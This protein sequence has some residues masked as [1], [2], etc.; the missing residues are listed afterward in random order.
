MSQIQYILILMITLCLSGCRGVFYNSPN[1]ALN[2]IDSLL[3]AGNYWAAFNAL[4]AIDSSMLQES[5]DARMR[6]ELQKIKAEDK[7]NKPLVTDSMIIAVI[8]YYEEEG[9]KGTLP[10]AYYYAGRTYVSLYDAQRALEYFNKALDVADEGDSYLLSKIHSQRGE[11]FRSQALYDMALKDLESFYQYADVISDSLGMFAALSDLGYCYMEME[12]YE[13]SLKYYDKAFDLASQMG[14][15]SLQ[16]YANLR[17]A[18]AYNY[19]DNY[20]LAEDFMKSSMENVGE[21][22]KD[23]ANSIAGY[24]F[25]RQ[26]KYELARPYYEQM[27][28]SHSI[29]SR[30]Q[31]EAMLLSMA[32]NDR[33]IDEIIKHLV[34][35][36]ELTDSLSLITDSGQIARI[37]NLYNSQKLEK[38]KDRLKHLNM[39]YTYFVIII[40]LFIMVIISVLI[41]Y[42]NRIRSDR[43]RLKYNNALL[44][45]YLKEEQLRRKEAEREKHSLLQERDRLINDNMMEQL[46]QSKSDN[47]KQTIFESSIYG[48]LLNTS[49]GISDKELIEVEELINNIFPDFTTRLH[50]LG[51]NKPQDL[52]VCLLLKMG[53]SP[54]HIASLLSRRES[55]ITNSRKRLYKKVVGKEGKTEEFDKIIDGI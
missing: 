24:I 3:D 50:T 41:I 13:T 5:H 35:Y 32:A 1:V 33:N 47:R 42:G 14:D 15:K 8:D 55:T 39:Q 51:V 45:Q 23:I 10:E 53:F 27:L 36:K 52:R 34:P 11:I 25:F 16:S 30:Q 49:K 19:M 38:E 12:E 54:S 37:N 4:V 7:I 17:K 44:D 26:H 22:Y 2:Y 43:D 9:D 40:G 46:R 21:D 18:E 48:R 28:R 29:G 31:A 20:D 6:F